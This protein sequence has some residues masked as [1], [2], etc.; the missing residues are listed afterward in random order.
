MLYFCI[1]LNMNST[2]FLNNQLLLQTFSFFLENTKSHNMFHL[3]NIASQ[4]ATYQ[5]LHSQLLATENTAGFD[6]LG[7]LSFP[8][9]VIQYHSSALSQVWNRFLRLVH[10]HLLSVKKKKEHT[11][12]L[13]QISTSESVFLGNLNANNI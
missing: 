6:R 3:L 5:E 8:L 4:V 13:R 1:Q 10:I 2:F 9:L 12:L 7:L 11:R